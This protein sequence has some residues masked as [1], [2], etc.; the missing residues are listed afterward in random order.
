M[1]S[2]P[3]KQPAATV[4]FAAPSGCEIVDDVSEDSP[5]R[6][7]VVKGRM[8]REMKVGI[9]AA[10]RRSRRETGMKVRG[11]RCGSLILPVCV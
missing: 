4:H 1:C 2:T 8:S 5:S 3:Q 9:V 11:V 6:V 7:D 10:M